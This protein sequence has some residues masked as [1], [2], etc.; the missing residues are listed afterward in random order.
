MKRLLLVDLSYQ[1]YRATASHPGLTSGSTFTGGLFG[2][3]ATLGKTVRETKATRMVVCQDVKPYLRSIDYPQY[4]LL[5]KKAQ[6]EELF[7]LYQESLA[8]INGLLIECGIPTWGLAGFEC[9][10]LI[11]YAANKYRHRFDHI[12]AASN[13]SDLYQLFTIPNFSVYHSN[14]KNL[15]NG[16]TL[17][18]TKGLTPEQ[19][20]IATAVKGTHNDIEGI[21]GVGEITAMKIVKDDALLRRCRITYPGI[22]ERNLEL[23]KLPHPKFPMDAA[24]PTNTKPFSARALYKFCSRFDIEVT[25]SMVDCFEQ[26]Q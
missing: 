24:M 22:I 20:M 19:Y 17:M 9:D 21:K 18:E 23:I 2:F 25:K 11:G 13:D 15:M 12:Y 10:D 4:K 8:L 14:I 26:V 3:L 5:R 7:K 1:A 6:N 16:K